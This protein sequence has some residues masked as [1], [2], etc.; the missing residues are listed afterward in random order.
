MYLK[1]NHQFEM[2]FKTDEGDIT[3]P[4]SIYSQSQVNMG[5]KTIIFV[6]DKQLE[7]LRTKS[8]FQALELKGDYALTDVEPAG[9]KTPAEVVV[10]KNEENNALKAEIDKLKKEVEEYKKTSKKAK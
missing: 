5:K 4:K 3:L 6:S 2:T 7:Q 8:E 1:S 10:A 9:F